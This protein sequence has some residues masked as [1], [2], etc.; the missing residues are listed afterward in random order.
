[1]RSSSDPS[2]SLSRRTSEAAASSRCPRDQIPRLAGGLR[3]HAH[4]KLRLVESEGK[5]RGAPAPT[6]SCDSIPCAS[7]R[8]RTTSASIEEWLRKI[9]AGDPEARRGGRG[10]VRHVPG[11]LQHDHRH[12]VVRLRVADEGSDLAQDALADPRSVQLRVGRHDARR[13][14]SS[15]NSSPSRSI[16]SVMPSVYSTITSPGRHRSRVLLEH[17]LEALAGPGQPQPEHH[18]RR[19]HDL[20]RA[21]RRRRSA[22]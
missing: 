15:P 14:A 2:V 18:P 9:I 16:A 20:R 22:A 6:R 5:H 4:A 17:L 10:R 7:S 13:S 1:M 21:V 8:P 19:H 11:H 12:V 3:R